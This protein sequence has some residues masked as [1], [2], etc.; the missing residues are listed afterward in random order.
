ME[1]NRRNYSGGAIGIESYNCRNRFVA[2]YASGI[3][4]DVVWIDP[5]FLLI[6]EYCL[7]YFGKKAKKDSMLCPTHIRNPLSLA[8]MVVCIGGS[9]M[10]VKAGNTLGDITGNVK[11]TDT[12]SAY[13]MVDDPAQTLMDAKDYV[14][15]IT[16]NTITNIPKR[17]SKR[18]MKLSGHRSVRRCMTTF[19]IWYRHCMREALMQC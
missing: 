13:V 18:S 7:F 9:Y 4:C 6:M 12:V 19:L 3:V 14:F 17:Q 2:E 1:N 15:A 5:A 16:E 11:T 8:C 10:L